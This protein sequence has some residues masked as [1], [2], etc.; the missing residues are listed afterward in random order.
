MEECNLSDQKLKFRQD[1]LR[2]LY[3]NFDNNRVIYEC[4]NDWCSK[5]VTTNGIVSYCKA[6]Y[7]TFSKG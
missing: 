6:Y 2:I 1:V 3:R 4:A 7:G 5:Q